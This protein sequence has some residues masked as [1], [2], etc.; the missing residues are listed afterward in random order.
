MTSP[1]RKTYSPHRA[2]S[3]QTDNQPSETGARARAEF[4]AM[5]SVGDALENLDDETRARVLRWAAEFFGLKTVETL[6]VSV[7]MAETASPSPESVAADQFLDVSASEL[8]SFFEPEDPAVS[9]S[10]PMSEQ[11]T[12]QP[13]A[14]MLHGFVAD[15]QQLARDWQDAEPAPAQD[16]R[17]S[18]P[19]VH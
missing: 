11:D 15:V 5:R 16:G 9:E 12:H 14:S 13:V 10:A 6:S 2:E 8:E 1:V 7:S 17:P 18:A 4:A 3:A 19:P